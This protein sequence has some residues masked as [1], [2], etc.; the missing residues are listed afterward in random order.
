LQHVWTC[1]ILCDI[2]NL[3]HTPAHHSIVIVGGSGLQNAA[4]SLVKMN[5]SELAWS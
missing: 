2:F 1:C 4:N 5:G 3:A